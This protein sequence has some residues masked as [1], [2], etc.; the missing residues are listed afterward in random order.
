MVRYC[1]SEKA[2]VFEY[3]SGYISVIGR[4]YIGDGVL[5]YG[6][7]RYDGPKYINDNNRNSYM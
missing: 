1:I 6:P 3:I 4:N 7:I 2:R 5:R